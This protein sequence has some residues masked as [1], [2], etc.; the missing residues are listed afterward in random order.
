LEEP[1]QL[2]VVLFVLQDL[3]SERVV[4]PNLEIDSSSDNDGSKSQLNVVTNVDKGK[5]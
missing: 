5:E 2:E 3:I 4:S 1:L